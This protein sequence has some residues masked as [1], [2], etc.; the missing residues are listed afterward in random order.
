MPDRQGYVRGI[1]DH[2][3]GVQ[4]RQLAQQQRFDELGPLLV[5]AADQRLERRHGILDGVLAEPQHLR[6][7]HRA[8]R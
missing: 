2:A 6:A 1:G 5:V 3:E 7:E 4:E 8:M